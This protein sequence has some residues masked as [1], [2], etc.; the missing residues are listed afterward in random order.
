M[1]LLTDGDG[2]GAP[3]QELSSTQR[4]ILEASRKRVAEARKKGDEKCQK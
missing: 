2:R 3:L 1:R 4:R